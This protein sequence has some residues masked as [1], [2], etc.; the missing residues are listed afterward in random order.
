MAFVRERTA[1][2]G[3]PKHQNEHYGFPVITKQESRLMIP[4]LKRCRILDDGTVE[5]RYAEHPERVQA[6]LF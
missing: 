6:D 4:P 3:A 2:K 1:A 5:V